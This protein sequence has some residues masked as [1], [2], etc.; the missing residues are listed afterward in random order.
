[1]QLEVASWLRRAGRLG[2]HTDAE[3]SWHR[4]PGP[5]NARAAPSRAAGA[6]ASALAAARAH[7]QESPS[8]GTLYPF[9]TGLSEGREKK[10]MDVN[11]LG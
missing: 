10:P 7:W 1:M 4:D 6:A 9:L 3:A 5:M 2:C 11:F 8:K